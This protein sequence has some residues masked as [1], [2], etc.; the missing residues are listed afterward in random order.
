MRSEQ[1]IL[2]KKVELM[3]KLDSSDELRFVVEVSL[4]SK[5]KLLEWVLGTSET[6]Q[7]G[8]SLSRSL[9]GMQL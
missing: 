1:E 7:V 8:D 9:Q 2:N 4:E 5:I 6:K 3:N